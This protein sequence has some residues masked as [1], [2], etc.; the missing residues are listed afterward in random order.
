MGYAALRSGIR[1]TII[2][3]ECVV[4][5]LDG[6]LRHTNGVLPMDSIAKS[7]GV[8]TVYVPYEDAQE[9]GLV[10]GLF[11]VY[12]HSPVSVSTRSWVNRA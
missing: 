5:L 11:P 8:K 4:L 3:V 7:H 10:E 9:A 1:N 12:V 6:A 2:C